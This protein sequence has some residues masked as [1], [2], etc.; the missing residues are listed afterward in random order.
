MFYFNI[1]LQHPVP[2]LELSLHRHCSTSSINKIAHFGGSLSLIFIEDYMLR[3]N[4]PLSRVY[5]LDENYCFVLTY[6]PLT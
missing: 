2:I 4:W 5:I 1:E 6:P 3:P